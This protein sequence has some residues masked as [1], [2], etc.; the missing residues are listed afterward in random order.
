MC[1]I[2][3]VVVMLKLKTES[4][5]VVMPGLLPL[6]RV[7]VVANVFAHTVPTFTIGLSFKVRVHQ[8]LHSMVVQTVRFQ[9]VDN[10]EPVSATSSG[11]L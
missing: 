2:Y 10:V 6:Y 11:V 4:K 9:K 1:K 7:L 3:S 5:G 8:W